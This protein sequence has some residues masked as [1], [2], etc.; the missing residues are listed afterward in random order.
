MSDVC[1]LEKTFF[2]HCIVKGRRFRVSMIS[3]NTAAL[4]GQEMQ[5]RPRL[6]RPVWEVRW[7]LWQTAAAD[8][9]LWW[10]SKVGPVKANTECWPDNPDFQRLNLSKLLTNFGKF[11]LYRNK[12][13]PPKA[14]GEMPLGCFLTGVVLLFFLQM[15]GNADYSIPLHCLPRRHF[16]TF[17]RL[18]LPQIQNVSSSFPLIHWVYLISSIWSINFVCIHTEVNRTI[19]V[20]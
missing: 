2:L 5:H 1:P 11:K 8:R 17:L 16:L 20:I 13:E 3:E 9:P 6:R 10:L 14:F 19:S 15:G 12:A 18:L 4:L 7:P